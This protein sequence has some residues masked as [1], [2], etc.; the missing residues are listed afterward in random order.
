MSVGYGK[1]FKIG[2]GSINVYTEGNGTPAIVILS[3][4]GVTS[5]VLEYRPLYRKLS[6]D[7]RIAVVE[8]SG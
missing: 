4:A 5:P 2:K 8:K 7:Y 6:D 1:K 3:G